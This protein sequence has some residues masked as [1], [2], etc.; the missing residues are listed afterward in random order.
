MA[1]F[2]YADACDIGITAGEIWGYLNTNGASSLNRIT[3]NL[4]V[5]REL[6]LQ[7]IGWLAREDKL[8]FEQTSRGRTIRLK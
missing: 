5:S 2:K 8:V 1:E 6:A 7:A 3:T 4:K